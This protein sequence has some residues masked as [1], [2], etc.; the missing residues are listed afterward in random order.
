MI[1]TVIQKERIEQLKFLG[2]QRRLEAEQKRRDDEEIIRRAKEWH[3][4]VETKRKR[5]F[6]V[7]KKHQKE[8]L[9]Q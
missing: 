5:R 7:N 3:E 1:E 9:D 4:L 6:E 2:E 8:I